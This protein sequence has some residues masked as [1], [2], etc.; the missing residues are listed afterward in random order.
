MGNRPTG[1]WEERPQGKQKVTQ[2]KAEEN[3]LRNRENKM[4]K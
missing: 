2:Q 3:Q 4:I 1:D